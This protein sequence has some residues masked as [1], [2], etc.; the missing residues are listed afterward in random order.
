[1]AQS[2]VIELCSNA[3]CSPLALTLTDFG[4]ALIMELR[5]GIGAHLQPIHVQQIHRE[6]NQNTQTYKQTKKQRNNETH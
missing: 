6:R 5:P 3:C 2:K 4:W 1:M